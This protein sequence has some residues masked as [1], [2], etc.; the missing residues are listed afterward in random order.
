[1]AT[2]SKG[3]VFGATESVTN[4]KLHNLVDLGSISGIVNADI[5][6]SAQIVDTKLADISTGN[7]VSGAA[8]KLL[9]SIPTGAGTI[10]AKNGGTGGDMATAAQGTVPYFSAAGVM[11]A[12]AVGTA[13]QVFSTGGASANPSWINRIN[14]MVGST[15]FD[16]TSATGTNLVVSGVGFQPEALLLF[17]GNNGS[18]E[19]MLGLGISDGSTGGSIAITEASGTGTSFINTNA[20][21]IYYTTT[22]FQTFTVTFS[23]DGFTLANTKTNSPLGTATIKYLA[24][25]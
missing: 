19:I 14:V 20:L 9:G 21:S 22:A 24:I 25:G 6:A 8:L 17:A 7:K 5:D 4:T 12:L 10:P 2:L 18:N 16:L 1:M 3:Y 15:T 23:A 11:S 13:G